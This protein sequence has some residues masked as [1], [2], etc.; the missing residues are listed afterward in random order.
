MA[1]LAMAT[2]IVITI[3][4]I[5]GILY[6]VSPGYLNRSL[7]I[8]NLS[9]LHLFTYIFIYYYYTT[10]LIIVIPGLV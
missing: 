6:L 4:D 9:S 10:I 5:T 3:P 7:H 1:N 8:V 2:T